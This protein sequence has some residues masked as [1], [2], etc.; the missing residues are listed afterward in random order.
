RPRRAV[1]G[2]GGEAPPDLNRER[3]PA[4]KRLISIAA[5]LVAAAAVAATAYFWPFRRSDN[6]LH[7]P[8]TVEIQEVRIGSKVGGRVASVSVREGQVVEAGQEIVRF[9]EPELE[10]QRD[11]LRSKLAAA[12][13]DLLKARNGPRP[14]EKDEARAA[15]ASAEARLQRMEAGWREEEKRQARNDA[16]AAEAD[17]QLWTEE[18]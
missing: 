3:R 10:A 18:Y 8:G 5:V 6:T 17:F 9:E 16:E 14:E 12:E 15:L 4:V 11:Q 13:A 2:R 7:M 1:R